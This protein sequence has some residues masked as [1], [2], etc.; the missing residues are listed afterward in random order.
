MSNFEIQKFGTLDE[1]RAVLGKKQKMVIKSS[2]ASAFTICTAEYLWAMIGSSP[3]PVWHEQIM[4]HFARKFFIDIDY[5]FDLGSPQDNIRRVQLAE[6]HFALVVSIA[7]TKFNEMFNAVINDVAV[8]DSSGEDGGKGKFS[9]NIIIPGF[10][11]GGKDFA[12]LGKKIAEDY[13]GRQNAIPGFIDRQQYTSGSFANRIVGC[14]KEGSMRKKKVHLSESELIGDYPERSLLITDVSHTRPV[15]EMDCREKKTSVSDHITTAEIDKFLAATRPYWEEHFIFRAKVGGIIAFNRIAPSYCSA[16]STTH[17]HDHTLYGII[18]D[19]Y[20]L[21]C[22][23]SNRTV[24]ITAN[25]NRPPD[26]IVEEYVAPTK[27]ADTIDLSDMLREG[28]INYVR[29]NTKTGKTNRCI[30]FT[31]GMQTVVIVS[32]RRTFTREIANRFADMAVYSDIDG[33]ISLREYPRVIVQV[34]SLHRLKLTPGDYID[35]LILDESESIISQFSNNLLD[36]SGTVATFKVLSEISGTIVAMDANLGDRTRRIC[37]MMV[38]EKPIH[39]FCSTFNRD[40]L[41][42]Y[43]LDGR[44]V[45]ANTKG[46]KKSIALEYVICDN[47]QIISRI[48]RDLDSRANIAIF[49]N[50]LTGAKS[51]YRFVSQYVPT[52]SIMMYTSETLESI[53]RTHFSNVDKYWTKYRVIICTPTVTAGISY[54]VDHFRS[55]YGWFTRHSCDVETCHQ[56][57]NRVRSTQGMYICPDDHIGS[58]EY[59]TTPAAVEADL[60]NRREDLLKLSAAS[61][62]LTFTFTKAMKPEY[63]KDL[64][65][66]ITV[67]NIAHANKSRRDF[68]GYF[69]QVLKANYYIL[70]MD[71]FKADPDVVTL[72]KQAK[73]EADQHHVELVNAAKDVPTANIIAMHAKQ[74]ASLDISLAERYEEIRHT[75]MKTL[76]EQETFVEAPPTLAIPD[77]VVLYFRRK[78][79][80]DAFVHTRDILSKPGTWHERVALCFQEDIQ[81][82]GAGEEIS[83]MRS[84]RHVKCM[85]LCKQFDPNADIG[86]FSS[87]F[88]GTKV[89]IGEENRGEFIAYALSVSESICGRVIKAPPDETERYAW[90]VLLAILKDVY[91]LKA[92]VTSA[93]VCTKGISEVAFISDGRRIRNALEETGSE[94]PA[95]TIL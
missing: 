20:L 12:E 2:N 74:K 22:R 34:D 13:Y 29:V 8:V 51:I 69:C 80:M 6:E 83:E 7:V 30:E 40:S 93:R 23:K 68:R 61:G 25:I 46:S 52:N 72:Y 44:I 45:P 95:I 37:G 59:S 56:M 19:D 90:S 11:M 31:E 50:S 21:R 47:D 5:T 15:G 4:D 66:W 64:R 88:T 81:R 92:Q 32:F 86:W 85:E 79:K 1:V 71:Q 27:C 62:D 82:L 57:I 63:T 36:Y 28:H 33:D 70:R 35:A 43:K 84:Q 91:I 76:Y 53:K 49:T 41:P 42:V 24:W 38:P 75:Y 94:H 17:D 26:E 87:L 16:C 18:S 48:A 14:V 73:D 58:W 77:E 89:K 3:N 10:R 78:H 67:Y 9:R 54:T 65:Y 55:V 39:N 60:V